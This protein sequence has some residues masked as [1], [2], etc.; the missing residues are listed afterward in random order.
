[1]VIK[2]R[3]YFNFHWK[4]VLPKTPVVKTIQDQKFRLE[5]CQKEDGFMNKGFSQLKIPQIGFT[6]VKFFLNYMKIGAEI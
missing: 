6:K 1:M 5:S 2:Y 4:I 3:L